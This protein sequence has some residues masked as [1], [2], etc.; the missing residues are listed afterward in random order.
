MLRPE[1][2]GSLL[3][4]ST[5]WPWLGERTRRLDGAHIAFFAAL[6][7]PVAVKVGPTMTPEE[8]LELCGQLDPDREAGR[9]T[10]ISRMGAGK[11]AERLP[12]LVRA[13]RAAGHP[14][15]WLCDPMHGNT[16]STAHGFKTRYVETIVKEVEEF[17]EAVLENGGV[18]GG[19][20]LETTPDDVRECVQDASRVA[21]IGEKYTSYCDPRLNPSQAFDVISVW[22]A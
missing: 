3:L 6:A 22:H 21:D 12:A 19:L 17:Q 20:H 10:L 11:A 1:P 15:I 9:L 16:V 8:L 13:A 5:H 7:N 4:T 18:A 14:V 2:D